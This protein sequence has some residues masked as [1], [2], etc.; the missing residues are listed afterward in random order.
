MNVTNYTLL[1]QLRISDRDI[2]RRKELLDFTQED[3]NIL[4][5]LKP[6]IAEFIDIIVDDFYSVQVEVE[7]IAR[8]IG[9]AETLLRLKKHMR[10][11]ILDLFDGEYGEDYIQSRLRIGM[12]H[13]RIGVTPK[14]YLSAMR[15]LQNLIL[16]K[17]KASIT[18]T[19]EYPDQLTISES[20]Q[21]LILLDLELV[22]DTYIH[23]LMEE[24][25]RSKEDLEKY[26]RTLEETVNKRT[27][28]LETI[29]RTDTLTGLL[30]K[31]SLFDEIKRE[32]SRSQRIF[33]P[34][35]LVYFD[36]D[37]FKTIND[38]KGHLEG[39]KILQNISN[40]ITKTLREYDAAGR[41]G[42]DEFCIILPM[43]KK[44]E[45]KKFGDR[46][47]KNFDLVHKDKIVTLS[48]GIAV[49]NHNAG[50]DAE[51]LVKMADQAMYKAKDVKGHAIHFAPSIGDG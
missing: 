28:E 35:S 27:R 9:D 25:H 44:E 3:K 51:T 49:C 11:Y 4:L 42:G 22:F 13:K 6:L 24:I 45:A 2:K 14:L 17:I 43:T 16:Q 31:K 37:H 40:S 7:E 12:V 33:E 10:K 29:A 8:L 47:I 34:V 15:K 39:D 30:N 38:S 18:G 21:K 1:E 19:S 36:L 32:L 26:T 50:I 46:L 41:F 20:L 5:S 23:S 48:I